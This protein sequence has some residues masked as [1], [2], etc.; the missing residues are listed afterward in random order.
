MIRY[1]QAI[2]L[3]PFKVCDNGKYI[4]NGKS[5]CKVTGEDYW[6][7]VDSVGLGGI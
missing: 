6:S 2:I 4:N 5:G 1:N 7:Y 3:L